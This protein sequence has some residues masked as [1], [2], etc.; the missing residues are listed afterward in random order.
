MIKSSLS[1]LSFEEIKDKLAPLFQT[2]GL[3]LVILF[4]SA[5]TGRTH[6]RSDIDLAFLFEGPV[7]IL[8]LTNQVTKLLQTDSVDVVD[9]RRASPLLRYSAVKNGR[10]LYER[11][12]GLFNSFYSLA[13]RSYIDTKKLRDA[14]QAYIA[15]YL[16]SRGLQ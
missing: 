7:D 14:Q 2:E 9:L 13:V 4:G 11:R 16:G 10:L 1:P 12:E 6:Q 3:E 15:R 5:A 8:S